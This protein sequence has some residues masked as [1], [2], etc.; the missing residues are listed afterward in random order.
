M[1]SLSGRR[2][3][4]GLILTLIQRPPPPDHFPTRRTHSTMLPR[5]TSLFRPL[6]R[7]QQKLLTW[8]PLAKQPSPSSILPTTSSPLQH[9]QTAGYKTVG[10][11]KLRCEHCFFCAR[12]G[13][14]RVICKVNARHKQVQLYD[15]TVTKHPW[16]R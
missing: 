15:V 10:V 11:L 6:V 13:K 9:Q 14:K 2:S 3:L 16:S 8:H 12:R 4:F 5:L 7:P 1:L